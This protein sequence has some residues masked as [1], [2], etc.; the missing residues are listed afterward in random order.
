MV[1]VVGVVLVGGVVLVAVRLVGSPVVAATMGSA[2]RPCVA[3]LYACR[4]V[5]TEKKG[6]GIK[7]SSLGT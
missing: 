7:V 6:L 4:E 1:L 3:Q 2:K 5:L